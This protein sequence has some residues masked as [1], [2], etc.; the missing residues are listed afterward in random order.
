MHADPSLD[1]NGT[2][3]DFTDTTDGTCGLVLAGAPVPLDGPPTAD[4]PV[5]IKTNLDL[6]GSGSFDVVPVAGQTRLDVSAPWHAPG[7]TGSALPLR[8]EINPAGFRAA[9]D[10]SGPMGSSRVHLATSPDDCLL[11]Q[12]SEDFAAAQAGVTLVQAMSTYHAVERTSKYTVL[13]LTLSFLTYSL[14]ETLSGVPISVVRYAL[15][16]FSVS[17]FAL[18]LVSLAEPLGFT[19]G[20]AISAAL[21]SLQGALFTASVTRRVRLAVIF[22]VVQA[23]MFVALYIIINL[24]TYALLAGSG[25]LF[26]ALSTVMAATRHLNL[27]GTAPGE[28]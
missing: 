6:R 5:I 26:V 27:G 21:V 7:F 25:L 4:R 2:K 14:F 20:Y 9:W 15:L 24:E 16:G 28:T 22:I 11:G 8:S 19:V 10:M 13:F 23:I 1:W 3:V 12:T 17:L 18:L